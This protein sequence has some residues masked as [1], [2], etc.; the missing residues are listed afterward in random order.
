MSLPSAKTAA[1][2]GFETQR[3]HHQKSKT[4]A[5]VSPQKGLM[6]S[7]MFFKEVLLPCTQVAE[8]NVFFKTMM[9]PMKQESV[10]R[11]C[12]CNAFLPIVIG[13]LHVVSNRFSQS[14][15]DNVVMMILPSSYPDHPLSSKSRFLILSNIIPKTVQNHNSF[16]LNIL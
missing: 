2:F 11:R 13:Q 1:H 16:M 15:T 9:F 14:E 5:L 12:V 3:R 6:S 7:K 4:G 8:L 10:K